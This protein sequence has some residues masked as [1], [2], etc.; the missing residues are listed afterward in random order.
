MLYKSIELIREHTSCHTPYNLCILFQCKE[1]KFFIM[2]GNKL[3]KL[4]K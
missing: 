4:V 1:N 3:I 2:C